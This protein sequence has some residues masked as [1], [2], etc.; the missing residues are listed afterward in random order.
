MTDTKD[1]SFKNPWTRGR[2]TPWETEVVTEVSDRKKDTL[3]QD[4]IDRGP[5]I[6]KTD[7][8]GAIR[9]NKKLTNYLIL[10]LTLLAALTGYGLGWGAEVYIF[11]IQYDSYQYPSGI[12]YYN[13]GAL[14]GLGAFVTA[15]L[16]WTVYALARG[17]EYLLDKVGAIPA[18]RDLH[19][20]LFNVTEEMAIASGL[21][22][23][24]VGILES[25]AMNAFAAGLSPEK[26]TICVTTGL[27]KHCSRDQL[28]GVIA[29]EMS[30]ILNDDIRYKTVVSVLVGLILLVG[31]S[32]QELSYRRRYR[33]N[34]GSSYSSSS[35]DDKGGNAIGAAVILLIS[36]LAPL[37]AKLIQMAI[38]R[39]REYLA[40]ATA[41][42]LTRY[43]NGLIGALQKIS[44]A[45]DRYVRAN[46]SIQHLF[47]VNP[48]RDFPA[49]SSKLLAT[50]PPIKM[51]IERLQL[52]GANGSLF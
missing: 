30:H 26:A 23:P 13:I 49:K 29:H 15:S 32:M 1:Q 36:I 51:R 34:Y 28:Q 11:G 41:V 31:D 2:R 25:P 27:L 19:K 39:Q 47:L 17:D 10:L 43:P 3:R 42:K 37:A 8:E 50:H 24:S 52:L 21:P 18:D 7:F 33:S 46:R 5:I 40:D 35:S 44:T 20:R 6:L 45:Q 4:I 12:P 14:I 16:L 22:M 9:H 48:F 38:S